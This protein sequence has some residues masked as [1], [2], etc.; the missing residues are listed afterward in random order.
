MAS[1]AQIAANQANA[2][3]STG[4][5][6]DEGKARSSQNALKHGLC[7]ERLL[8]DEEERE[9]WEALRADY[10]DRLR[11]VGLAEA[12]LAERIAQVAW[13]R[14]R[15]SAM[16]AAAWRGHARGGWLIDRKD[17]GKQRWHEDSD[18]VVAARAT[19][20][21]NGVMPELL[22][23]ALYEGRL[24]RELQRL[25]AELAQMQKARRDRA[26]FERVEAEW[27]ALQRQADALA[28]ALMG[29]RPGSGASRPASTRLGSLSKAQPSQPLSRAIGFVPSAAR[30]D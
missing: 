8:I 5:K 17:R 18:P 11:P 2:R 20:I 26:A 21:M 16:E 9:D 7:A 25:K 19:P 29:R 12:R 24:T 3:K 27:P 30:K 22:R 10:A 13:R 6:T 14:E 23:I 1:A 15:G 4:P 28:D